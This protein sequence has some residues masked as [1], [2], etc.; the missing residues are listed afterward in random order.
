VTC[1]AERYDGSIVSACEHGQV[2]L[3][4][5]NGKG[6]V[7]VLGTRAVVVALLFVLRETKQ[8]TSLPALALQGDGPP[9]HH[10]RCVALSEYRHSWL[11]ESD[12]SHSSDISPRQVDLKQKDFK[13][14]N[15]LKVV[16]SDTVV[17]SS[18]HSQTIYVFK[19]PGGRCVGRWLWLRR[20]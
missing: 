18:A 1:L 8:R 19:R 7:R 9:T 6:K 3:W 14:I 4:H 13:I 20:R 10:H 15:F 12:P 17:A 2:I 5:T 16:G 11:K